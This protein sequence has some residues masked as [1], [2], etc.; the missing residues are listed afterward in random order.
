MNKDDDDDERALPSGWWVGA[1]MYVLAFGA[2]CFF[3]GRYTA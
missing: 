2:I 3:I 1:L